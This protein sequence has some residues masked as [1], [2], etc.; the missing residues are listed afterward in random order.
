MC[1]FFLFSAVWW[2]VNVKFSPAASGEGCEQSGEQTVTVRER[3]REGD[4]T[5]EMRN[6]RE[7]KES[8]ESQHDPHTIAHHLIN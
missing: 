8:E 4:E 5:N 1:D 7:K 6:R 2:C 3:N